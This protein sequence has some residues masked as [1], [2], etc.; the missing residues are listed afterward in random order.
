MRHDAPAVQ[1]SSLRQQERPDADGTDAPTIGSPTAD[2]VDQ[3]AITTDIV[4]IAGAGDDQRVD[5]VSSERLERLGRY[6]DAV[7][8]HHKTA[9]DRVDRALIDKR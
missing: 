4:H 1:E 2:P 6:A 9:M 5:R 7:G 8:G 3:V